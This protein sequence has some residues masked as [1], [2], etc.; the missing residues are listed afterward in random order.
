MFVMMLLISISLTSCLGDDSGSEEQAEDPITTRLCGV[1]WRLTSIEGVTDES[2]I[3]P[4]D[5]Y[6]FNLDGNGSHGYTDKESGEV[7]SLD[8]T[9]K[10]YTYTGTT[11]R[12]VLKYPVYG[13][14]EFTTIYAIDNDGKLCIVITDSEGNNSVAYYSVVAITE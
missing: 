4:N 3:D 14:I 12:L 9:W 1:T 11:H 2:E 7:K 5:S 6:V 13:E 10:S 8:F